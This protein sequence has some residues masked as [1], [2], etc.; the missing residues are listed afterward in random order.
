MQVSKKLKTTRSE[1][2]IK[3]SKSLA[4]LEEKPSQQDLA[5]KRKIERDRAEKERIAKLSP[6]EQRKHIERERRG[7]QKSWCQS[8]DYELIVEMQKIR[9]G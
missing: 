2:V 3:F 5:Q 7:T 1:A 8:H 4:A 9:R 6:E